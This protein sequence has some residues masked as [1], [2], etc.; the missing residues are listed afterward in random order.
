[1]RNILG[2]VG[3]VTTLLWATP[4]FAC[5]TP[6][7]VCPNTSDGSFTLIAGG[8][9]ATV[10]VEA[11]SDSAVRIAADSFAKDLERV[12]GT[13]PRY[14]VDK[15]FNYVDGAYDRPGPEMIVYKL[16]DCT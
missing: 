15:S 13:M 3:V 8:R 11:A 6:V 14:Q 9:P 1:M 12:S 4:A 2:A 5:S 16:R 7:S 10:I